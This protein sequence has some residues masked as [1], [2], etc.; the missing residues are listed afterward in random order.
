MG[1]PDDSP[2]VRR[3]KSRVSELITENNQ[4][5]EQKTIVVESARGRENYSDSVATQ[6]HNFFK[7]SNARRRY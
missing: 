4:L 6:Q 2:E 5:R 1:A 3:L 7:Y